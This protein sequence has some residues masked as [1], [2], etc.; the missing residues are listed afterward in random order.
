MLATAEGTPTPGEHLQEMPGLNMTLIKAKQK[1]KAQ[2]CWTLFSTSAREASR[3]YRRPTTGV[4]QLMD[5]IKKT[6]RLCSNII[7]YYETME[8]KI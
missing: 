1:C 5:D 6:I 8:I 7:I 3:L 4:L 2:L